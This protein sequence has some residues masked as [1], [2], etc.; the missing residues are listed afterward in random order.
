MPCA[1]YTD[2]DTQNKYFEGNRTSVEVINL[3]LLQLQGRGD[4]CHDELSG[5]L[6]L[7]KGCQDV[8]LCWY[9]H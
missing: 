8:C 5:K 2:V 1:D 4:S 6:A 7:L 3:L 9:F